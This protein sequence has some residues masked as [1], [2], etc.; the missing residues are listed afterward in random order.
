MPRVAPNV[1][2]PVITLVAFMLGLQL[3]VLLDVRGR[4]DPPV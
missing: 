3:V 4:T 2:I 1:A